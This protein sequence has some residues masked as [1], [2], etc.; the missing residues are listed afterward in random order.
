M[1]DVI[2]A[3]LKAAAADMEWIKNAEGMIF[4]ISLGL[5]RLL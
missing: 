4:S 1:G 3:T 2:V 5:K